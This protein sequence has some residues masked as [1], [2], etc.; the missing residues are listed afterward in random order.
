MFDGDKSRPAVTKCTVIA[1]PLH[2]QSVFRNS[3]TQPVSHHLVQPEGKGEPLF[4]TRSR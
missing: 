1:C 3:Y 4:P 2:T